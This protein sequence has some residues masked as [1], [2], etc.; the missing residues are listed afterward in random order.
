MSQQ[1]D[2]S[3]QDLR[4]DIA[5]SCAVPMDWVPEDPLG[6]SDEEI[7]DYVT[8]KMEAARLIPQ[9]RNHPSR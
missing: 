7:V 2:A 4:K 6:M 5:L 3:L 8:E 9:T 1:E